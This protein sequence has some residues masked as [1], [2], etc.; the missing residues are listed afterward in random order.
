M[1][2]LRE[3]A[4]EKL[5]KNRALRAAMLSMIARGEAISFVGAGMSAPLKYPSWPRLLELLFP[6]TPCRKNGDFS[7]V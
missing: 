1:P 5:S 6:R 3:I 7:I 2:S 4:D